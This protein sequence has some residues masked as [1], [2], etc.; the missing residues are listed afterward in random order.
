[1]NA[2]TTTTW[3]RSGS[4]NL[5]LLSRYARVGTGAVGA[6]EAHSM[7]STTANRRS[8][9]PGLCQ[10]RRILQS[11]RGHYCLALNPRENACRDG[12]R[13]ALLDHFAPS[14]SST[15]SIAAVGDTFMTPR[16]GVHMLYLHFCQTQRSERRRTSDNTLSCDIQ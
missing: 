10:V 14:V 13:R 6:T 15:G 3:T 4:Q 12:G 7:L 5:A 11:L 8:T 9:S 2:G 1:M 16:P